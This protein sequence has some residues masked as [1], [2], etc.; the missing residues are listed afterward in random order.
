MAR[1]QNVPVALDVTE[2]HPPVALE[3]LL[4]HRAWVR[5]VARALV[6]DPNDADDVEQETWLAA[7]RR[8]PRHGGS[9]RGWLGAATRNVA[10]RLGRDAACRAGHEA[11]V[12]ARGDEAPAS[13]LVA[14]A[15][16]QQCI[17]KA[18]LEL[19]EPFRSTV[20][21]R[22]FDGLPP[23]EI[24]VR[25]QVPVETVRSRLRRAHERLR[26]RLD[27]D[28]GGR[29]GA[30]AV[31]VLAWGPGPRSPGPVVPPMGI[32]ASLGGALVN[33]LVAAAVVV[34]L[35]TTA[36]LTLRVLPEPE[37]AVSSGVARDAAAEAR[38][39]HSAEPRRAS[40]PVSETDADVAEGDELPAPIDLDRADRDL[41]LHGTVTDMEGRGVAGARLATVSYPWRTAGVLNA[42]EYDREALGPATRSA[43]DGTFSLRLA[44]G[45][46]VALRATAPGF[47]TLE[48]AHVLAGERV[49]VTLRPGVRL[50]VEMKDANGTPVADA[51][52]DVRSGEFNDALPSFR[53]TGTTG[54][55]G[56]GALEGLP[57]GARAR[58]TATHAFKGTAYVWK[59]DLPTSGELRQEVRLRAARTLRGRV[60][61]ADSKTPIA[62]ARVGI[63]WTLDS[64]VTTSSDGSYALPGWTGDG[65]TDVHVRAEGYATDGK[66]VE[67]AERVDFELPRGYAASGRVVGADHEPVGGA[68][69]SLIAS[70]M[71]ESRQQI[72]HAYS[73]ADGDGRFRVTGL[74]VGMRHVV[75]VLAP[76][77]ARLR[78]ETPS[79][80][81]A[82]DA[83]LGDLVLA[84][85]R[86]VEGV[87]VGSDGA[88]SQ[89]QSVFLSGP[90]TRDQVG[91]FYGRA[92]TIATDDLGRFRFG[93]VE[94]GDYEVVVRPAGGQE[95]RTKV[96]VPPDQDVL[97]IQIVR[98]AVR[99]VRIA[100]TDPEGKPLAGVFVGLTDS[101]NKSI[102]ERTDVAGVAR[103]IVPVGHAMTWSVYPPRDATREFLQPSWKPLPEDSDD[104]KA[105]LEE[106]GYV[107][108]RVT[109]PDDAPV[110]GAWLRLVGVDGDT[111]WTEAGAD[112]RFRARVRRVG[113]YEVVFDGAVNVQGSRKESG[114]AAQLAGV[115]P[116][117]DVALRCT[118]IALDRALV[119]VVVSPQGDPVPKA[120]IG[121]TG[122]NGPI[123]QGVWPRTDDAGQLRLAE[124]PARS[125][126][127]H[128]SV[129]SAEY[130][131]PASVTVVPD[132]QELRLV[133][134]AASRITGCVVDKSGTALP[135]GSAR[136]ERGGEGVSWAQV[137]RE[138][139]F[140]L[141]LPETDTLPVRVVIERTN[142]DT[143]EATQDGVAPGTQGLRLVVGK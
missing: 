33:K 51:T 114:L 2:S 31:A 38:G 9:V 1:T 64:P 102:Q 7:I 96:H 108:G 41:D 42:W 54:P 17:G 23:R 21:L 128:V 89:R 99:E 141:L 60:I 98:A 13:D 83:E 134:R 79:G 25:Q 78:R 52:L 74:R 55:D 28:G 100:V 35:A 140:A 56:V 118:R 18:V 95:I 105:V 8:P 24:A 77:H 12:G 66:I 127:V 65:Q 138:G 3:T 125:L 82:Q 4:A 11:S 45:R 48:L 61:D 20:L 39:G 109:D 62:G 32:A 119:V 34:V 84:S 116:G 73:R 90:L 86:R 15:E 85:P 113:R 139:R 94:P 70:S 57:S 126:Q 143:P 107:T 75:V 76:G 44:R 92:V 122:P 67:D 93:D 40:K 26:A 120:S 6:A 19:D 49:R 88:P 111:R 103:V 50:V 115:E 137:D 81:P 131:G 59:I 110:A 91:S 129:D 80:S 63:G 97:D 5:A 133:C 58:L 121:I 27:A 101:N 106:A 130:L 72:S 46:C 132:G 112:G 87:V 14:E 136:A 135:W 104:V 47:A 68:L 37:S 123:G 71:D 29:R 69:V 43:R 22:Y 36:W 142:D 10:R 117:A 124:L 53:A 30:W 16:L